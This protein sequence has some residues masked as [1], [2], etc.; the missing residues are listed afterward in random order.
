MTSKERRKGKE[1]I[2]FPSHIYLTSCV[3]DLIKYFPSI[4]TLHRLH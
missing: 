1:K 2:A 4:S 3:K